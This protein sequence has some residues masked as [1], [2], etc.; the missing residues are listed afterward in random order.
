MNKYIGYIAYMIAWL[1]TAACVVTALILTEGRFWGV[2][3]FMLI[4]A[5]ISV[6]DREDENGKS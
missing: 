4:P 2:I 3:F 6:N 5:Q 1:A